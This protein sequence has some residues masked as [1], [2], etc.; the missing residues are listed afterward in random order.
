MSMK[1][2]LFV[3]L[4]IIPSLAVRI[5]FIR[6][7]IFIPLSSSNSTII[8]NYTCT[9]CLCMNF[10]SQLLLNCFPN[11]TCQ[12]FSNFPQ[13]Y[14]IQQMDNA[15]LYFPQGIFPNASQCCMPNLTHLLNRLRTTTPIYGR[16]NN[17]RCLA[18]DD[19]G[20]VVTNSYTE[21]T[22]IRFNST[23]LRLIDITSGLFTNS[24][25]IQYYNGNYYVGLAERIV[26]ISSSSLTIQN[27]ITS[28]NLNGVRDMMFLDNGDTLVV[29]STFNH[30]LLFFKRPNNFS[31]NYNFIYQQN[32]NYSFPHGMF[33]VN[34]SFFYTIS[35]ANNT[36]WSYSEVENSTQ[37]NENLFIDAKPRAPT[38]AGDHITV[39]ECGR[40]WVSLA[41]YGV[42]V[43]DAK[44]EYLDRLSLTNTSIFETVITEN[45]VMYISDTLS[46]R[47]IRIDPDIEC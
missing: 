12:F 41:T 44:G 42:H 23:D 30:R 31:T 1:T 8:T 38:A 5:P 32:V 7:A 14:K 24:F 33:R 10:S 2:V 25:S 20:Y 40:S 16:V 37:W 4:L 22:I 6:N 19:H 34:D 47:I 17:P 28:I 3:F 46:Q 27:N 18:F 43:F 15:T 13:R 45:Y 9:Q 36:V 21:P 39:D 29:T 35:W 11:N 26:V